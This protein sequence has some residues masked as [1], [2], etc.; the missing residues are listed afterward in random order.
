MRTVV[1]AGIPTNPIH[2]GGWRRVKGSEK[3][4]MVM[5]GGPKRGWR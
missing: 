4:R 3:P 1:D 5:M 2:Q